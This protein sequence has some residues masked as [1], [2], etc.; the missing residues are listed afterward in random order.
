M[1]GT[2]SAARPGLP[3]GIQVGLG[4]LV[5][6]VATIAAATMPVSAGSWRVAP[7]AIAVLLF[8]L[9]PVRPV[10]AAFSALLGYLMVIGFLV[11]QYGQL[12]WHGAPDALR[13]LVI[14]AATTVGFVAGAVRRRQH[15]HRLLA[16]WSAPALARRVYTLPAREDVRSG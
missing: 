11:N 7:V 6:L 14:G 16:N 2:T 8:A 5:V 4:T 10:A 12:S 1:A 13:L 3:A 9:F 15:R